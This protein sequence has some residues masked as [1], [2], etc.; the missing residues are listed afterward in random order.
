MNYRQRW[1]LAVAMKQPY[2]R[3][4]TGATETEQTQASLLKIAGVVA[5]VGAIGYLLMR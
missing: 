2:P 1:L 3:P 5:A 4:D